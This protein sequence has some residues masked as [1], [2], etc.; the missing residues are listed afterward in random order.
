MCV[1]LCFVVCFRRTNITDNIGKV[2]WVLSQSFHSSSLFLICGKVA[3]W[4]SFNNITKAWGW[5]VGWGGS[6]KQV[7]LSKI[8]V[9]CLICLLPLIS[10]MMSLPHG[11]SPSP[12]SPLPQGRPGMS[13]FIPQSA[14]SPLSYLVFL[15]FL[16]RHFSGNGPFFW[17][18]F[19]K[20]GF[21]CMALVEQLGVDSW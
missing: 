9:I 21:F 8:L 15:L 20:R 16:S 7:M 19:V 5:G 2:R 12:H 14:L 18:F 3:W 10:S 4:S 6:S 13:D 11:L 1:Y 17:R